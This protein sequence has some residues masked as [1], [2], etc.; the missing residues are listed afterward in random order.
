MPDPGALYQELILGHSKNPRNFGPLAG[1]TH[2]AQREN[3]FCGDEITVALVLVGER[4]SAIRFHGAGCTIAMASSS[5]MTDELAGKTRAQAAALARNFFRLV[6]GH[7]G[8]GA[9]GPLD[10][11]AAVARFP[12]RVQCARL[13]WRALLAALGEESA[14]PEEHEP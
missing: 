13:P 14:A 2:Q 8:E 1:A 10:A 11:F 7:S 12:V 9:L 4:I 5:M 3:P 6:S